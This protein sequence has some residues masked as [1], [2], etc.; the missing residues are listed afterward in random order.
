MDAEEVVGDTFL[1]VWRH[2][3]CYDPD[4]GPVMAWLTVIVRHRAIDVLR[5]RRNHHS[6]DD[7]SA[8]PRVANLACAGRGPEQSAAQEQTSLMLQRALADLPQ[9]RRRLVELAFFQHLTHEEI[10]LELGMP[11]GTV[12]SH[13]RRALCRMRVA[14]ARDE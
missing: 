7:A 13:I 14:L 9:L 8:Q 10:S 5:K 1:Y 4:R 11:P 2:S 12:K 6:L 3:D